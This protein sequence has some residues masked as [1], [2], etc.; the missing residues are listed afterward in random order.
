[1]GTTHVDDGTSQMDGPLLTYVYILC[2]EL[3]LR[4]C[5]MQRESM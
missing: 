2:R 1:M 5:M 4:G 3:L